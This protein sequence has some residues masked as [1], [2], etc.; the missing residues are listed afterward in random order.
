MIVK[1][2]GI[3][4]VGSAL[5]VVIVSAAGV[6]PFGN[7]PLEIPWRITA[8]LII[9]LLIGISA[10]FVWM[11]PFQEETAFD[12][13]ILSVAFVL[14]GFTYIEV[15]YCLANE[16]VSINTF[17]V[18]LMGTASIGTLLGALVKSLQ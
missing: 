8:T 15:E 14:A 7:E 9:G 17:P 11:R 6:V 5:L 18:L 13:R 12:W 10:G 2:L 16:F 3:A 4:A 1:H